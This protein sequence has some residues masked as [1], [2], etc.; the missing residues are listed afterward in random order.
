MNFF[1]FVDRNSEGL[2]MVFIISL[3]FAFGSCG[4]G[5]CKVQM[6]SCGSVQTGKP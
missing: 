3:F 6:G 2:A 4:S 1:E 5:G